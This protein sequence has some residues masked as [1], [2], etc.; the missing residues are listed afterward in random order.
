MKVAAVKR[1]NE[2]IGS[3]MAQTYTRAEEADEIGGGRWSAAARAGTV[4]ATPDEL[5]ADCGGETAFAGVRDR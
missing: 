3:M 4:A 1:R 5:S 2:R